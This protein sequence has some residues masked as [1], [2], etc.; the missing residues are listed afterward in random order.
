[1]STQSKTG[2]LTQ[3]GTLVALLVAGGT[4]VRDYGERGAQTQALREADARQTEQMRR[5]NDRADAQRL[6]IKADIREACWCCRK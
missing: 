5:I 6:E 2:I 1:M 4:I 3:I